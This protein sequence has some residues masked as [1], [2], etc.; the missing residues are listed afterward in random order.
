MILTR[1]AAD[2]SPT[3]RLSAVAELLATGV[4]RRRARSRAESPPQPHKG[5]AEEAQVEAECVA[6]VTAPTTANDTRP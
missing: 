1:D 4:L 3:E 6:P 5:L 2:L